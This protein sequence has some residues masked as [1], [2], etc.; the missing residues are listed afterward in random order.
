MDN[1]TK[2]ILSNVNRELGGLLDQA[3]PS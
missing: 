2:G 1:L 3:C